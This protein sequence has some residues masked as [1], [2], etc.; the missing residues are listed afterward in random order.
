MFHDDNRAERRYTCQAR[1]LGA[2]TTAFEGNVTDLSSS[3]LCLVTS[4]PLESGRLLH[5]E[6]ELPE[7]RVEA[8]GEVRRVNAKHDVYELGIRFVR[9]PADALD[10]IR[11][12]TTGPSTS[13]IIRSVR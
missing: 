4:E 2:S 10:V 1:A 7:G 13:S 12:A 3:G 9:I 8:V 11:R 6:F 5:V